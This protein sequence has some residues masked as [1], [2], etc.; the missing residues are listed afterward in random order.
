[1]SK[2]VFYTFGLSVWSAA[3]ELAIAEL[4]Y[5]DDAIET[6]IVNLVEGE[7]FTPDFLKINPHATLPTLVADGEAYTSTK[8]VVHYL[9]EHA[10]KKGVAPGT[11]FIET[12]HEERLDPNA[13]LLLARTEEELT[14]SA[15]GFPFTFVNNR[16]N[17][18]DKNSALPE[19]AALKAIYDEKKAG[20]GAILA[21]YKGEAS[22]D[23]KQ[24]FLKQSVQHWDT[25][26][27][28]IL[29]ELPAVLPESGF[30]GGGSPGEDDFHLGA[31]LARIVH[32]AGGTADK[33]G[34]KSLEKETKKPIPQKVAAYWAAWIE[35]PSFRKVYVEGLH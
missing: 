26:A 1:M 4:G 33:D 10:P 34:Y 30:L 3:P 24:A 31:W 13:P 9:I 20:N 28:F 8:D 12:I 17:S 14:A 5:P 22:D 7:N 2:P 25:I 27:S 35:R 19:A 32:L 11:A 6:K 15:S 21:I 23:A 16:Q 18:L 29:N